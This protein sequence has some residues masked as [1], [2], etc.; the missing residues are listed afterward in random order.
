MGTSVFVTVKVFT[1][2]FVDSWENLKSIF[3]RT[4]SFYRNLNLKDIEK[5]N[6]NYAQKKLGC[7][8]NKES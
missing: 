8:Q 7:S 1:L 6:E 5:P 2:N 3:E 4:E